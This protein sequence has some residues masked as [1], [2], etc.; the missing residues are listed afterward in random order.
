MNSD[1]ILFA[2]LVVDVLVL[3]FGTVAL[4]LL[5]VE[6]EEL[7]FALLASLPVIGKPLVAIIKTMR[8]RS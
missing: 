7:R 6:G 4:I 2:L 3:V 8:K 1:T 5:R